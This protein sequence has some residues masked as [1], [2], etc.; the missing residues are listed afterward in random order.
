MD[1]N[2]V[3]A[4]FEVSDKKTPLVLA[5]DAD[6]DN[7]LLVKYVVEQ[8]NCTLLTAT[9]STEAL[10]L[11]RDNQPD[12][13]LLEMVLPELDGFEL[14]RLL[15]DSNLTDRISPIA[16]TQLASPRER[17]K[18]LDVGCEAYLSKPYLFEDLE[19]ILSRYLDRLP[20]MAVAAEAQKQTCLLP[21]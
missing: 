5:V 13:I 16:L 20:A 1:L 12:L 21:K 9:N 14:I 3:V 7:L 10:S 15:K 18:I 2:G 4:R 19:A 6:E 11:A 8:F 17:E